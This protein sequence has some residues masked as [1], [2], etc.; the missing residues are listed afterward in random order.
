MMP[1]ASWWLSSNA[2]DEKL[3]VWKKTLKPDRA[4]LANAKQALN[5]LD[6][7]EEK[8]PLTHLENIFKRIVKNKIDYLVHIV[9]DHR[10]SRPR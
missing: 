1:L 2:S 8:R 7:I 5:L 9:G 4:N 6:W 3:R 10:D